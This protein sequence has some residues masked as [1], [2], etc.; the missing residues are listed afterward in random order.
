[1]FEG[2]RRGRLPLNLSGVKVIEEP[3]FVDLRSGEID[4]LTLRVAVDGQSIERKFGLELFRPLL[5]SAITELLAQKQLTSSDQVSWH[6][7]AS[8]SPVRHEDG[9][10]S[11]VRRHPLLT[12]PG[13]LADFLGEATAVGPAPGD[14]YPL[15]V[16][17]TALQLA[18]EIIWER[19]RERGVWMVG[20]L[21]RQLDPE[22][23]IFGRI[24]TVFEARGAT[25]ERFRIDL[26]TET[27]IDLDTQLDR[28]RKR[29]GR[30][31]DV[32][33]GMAHT[34]PFLPS[35]LDGKEA[36]PS[37]PLRP[38]CHLSS[39]LLFS[40]QDRQFHNAVFGHVPFAVEFVLGLT[41]REEF[42]LRLYCPDSGSFRER[43]FYRL[44][45]RP[46]Q[47][48]HLSGDPVHVAT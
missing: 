33:M 27:F 24:H 34:H 30:L 44:A 11:V 10:R 6:V 38:T 8:P 18:H 42:D 2:Q 46:A 36:Y 37:C 39:A 20:N 7:F 48:S 3:S 9:V 17:D 19:N 25:H 16:T 15:F 13:Q 29:L 35:V 5:D 28:R 1:M 47:L 22:P 43:G 32:A 4:D 31:H 12:L 21:F 45:E 40:K 14:D 23:E 26:N 41:P